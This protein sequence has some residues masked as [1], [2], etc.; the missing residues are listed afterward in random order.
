MSTP[1]KSQSMSEDFPVIVTINEDDSITIEWDENHPVTSVFN[2]WT[3]K[4]F[5]DSIL[6]G[7]KDVIGE[8][9]YD[10]IKKEHL[11]KE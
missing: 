9:E 4:D 7:C 5:L 3:E 1:T 11:P 10:R 2:T 8:E 6:N